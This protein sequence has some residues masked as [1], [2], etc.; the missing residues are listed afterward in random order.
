MSD[1][2]ELTKRQREILQHMLGAGSSFN[3]KQWG[4]QNHFAC[5]SG[6]GDFNLLCKLERKGL[7]KSSGSSNGLTCFY[8]TREGALAIGFKQY[9]LR[10]ACL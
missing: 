5:H 6:G 1:E 9:Q 10:N 2:T 3:K 7:V 4:F 8:A